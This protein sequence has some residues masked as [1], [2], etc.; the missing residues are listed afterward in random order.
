M[1]ARNLS[2]ATCLCP[3]LLSFRFVLRR[4]LSCVGATLTTGCMELLAQP[5]ELLAN[6]ACLWIDTP[7][8][9]AGR[10]WERERER[11]REMEGGR[12]KHMV[13]GPNAW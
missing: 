12:N 6:P 13:M 2:L 9:F 11:H 1:A 7:T 8:Y 10:E 4:C 5:P 3:E